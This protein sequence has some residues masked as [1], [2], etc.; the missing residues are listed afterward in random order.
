MSEI[1]DTSVI[2]KFTPDTSVLERRFCTETGL[3]AS[4]KCTST[5]VGYYRKSNIPEYCS[6]NHVTEVQKIKSHWDEVDAENKKELEERL[7]GYY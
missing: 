1:E 6:G 7:N 5:D 3:I 4:A 2:S